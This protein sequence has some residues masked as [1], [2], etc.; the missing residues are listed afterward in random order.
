MPKTVKSEKSNKKNFG[1]GIK[2]SLT[3]RS[4]IEKKFG[5]KI[6]A[7]RWHF[8]DLFDDSKKCHLKKIKM[9]PIPKKTSF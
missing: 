5:K 9:C 3:R 1:M 8:Y 7:N 2:K 4:A 6:E